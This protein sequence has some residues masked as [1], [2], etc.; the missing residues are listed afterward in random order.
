MHRPHSLAYR[1][2]C[3]YTVP[4]NNSKYSDSG[5]ETQECSPFLS[6]QVGHF[7]RNA[8][9]DNRDRIIIYKSSKLSFRNVRFNR[10][11]TSQKGK[12]A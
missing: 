1:R 8:V 11:L 12:L 3:K 7:F 9:R 10:S 4:H 6:F 5:V 2:G